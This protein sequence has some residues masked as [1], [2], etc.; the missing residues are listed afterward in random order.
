MKRQKFTVSPLPHVGKQPVVGRKKW[1][2][3]VCVICSA[4]SS[5]FP[6]VCKYLQDCLLKH[7]WT[8][9]TY[10]MSLQLSVPQDSPVKCKGPTLLSDNDYSTVRWEWFI[11]L[12]S[13]MMSQT[14]RALRDLK[15]LCFCFCLIY[16]F[17]CSRHPCFACQLLPVLGLGWWKES[18]NRK[19]TSDTRL[20]CE[21]EQK[22]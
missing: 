8:S 11:G 2:N 1:V 20:P 13:T 5:L 15:I 4:I 3:I 18:K 10:Q 12:F 9:L 19:R 16:L 17:R 22:R 21:Q 7:G 14:P 6:R